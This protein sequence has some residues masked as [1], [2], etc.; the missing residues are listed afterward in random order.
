MVKG[1]IS[2]IIIALL[3]FLMGIILIN[4]TMNFFKLQ[5]FNQDASIV[6]NY[7][8]IRGSIQ[9]V[10]KL[11]LTQKRTKSLQRFIDEKFTYLKQNYIFEPHNEPFI[12]RYN[13]L[14]QHK[15]LQNSWKEI[16]TLINEG[17]TD[18]PS[19]LAAT[20]EC[21]YIADSLT[22]LTQKISEE[23]LEEFQS[24]IFYRVI[25]VL[26]VILSIIVIVILFVRRGLEKEV[27]LDPMTNI[28]NKQALH[29]IYEDIELEDKKMRYSLFILDIDYFK[30]VNDRYGHL[31][32]DRVLKEFVKVVQKNIRQEDIFIRY[33]GEEFIVIADVK[34]HNYAFA[35]HVRKSVKEH[36]FGLEET[37]T[38][39]IGVTKFK[40]D[41]SI[42]SVIGRADSALYKA[43]QNGRNRVEILND[44]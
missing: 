29:N 7:G 5:D 17:K 21:W 34:E 11:A 12:K 10:S 15:Q 44:I 33:G 35:D 39:S 9:R 19:F 8:V 6:N 30:Q 23:K 16:K 2:R 4:P 31:E 32:G 22:Y 18:T 27:M 38:V 14:Q 28:Y 1:Y 40:A 41:D 25:I 36:D 20:E 37:V 24:D 13:F 3:I 42:Q 43:K 26:A